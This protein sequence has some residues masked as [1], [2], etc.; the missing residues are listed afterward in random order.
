M[1]IDVRKGVEV[2]HRLQGE[3]KIMK[4][5]EKAMPVAAKK[6]MFEGIAIPAVIYG[7]RTWAVSAI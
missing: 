5:W 4:F 3:E 7:S 1:N 6:V 2:K